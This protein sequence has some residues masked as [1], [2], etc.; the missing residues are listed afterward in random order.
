MTEP[1]EI[2]RYYA[3]RK[4]F[5][6]EEAN[7]ALP[8][9]K[10]IARDLAELSREVLERRERLAL[11]RGRR[12]SDEQNPYAE[13]LAQIEDELAEDGK[14]LE[15]FV[16]EL[17]ELGVEPKNALEGLV[18]F[19]ARLEGRIVYLCWK[20]GEPE[21]LFWHDIEAGFAGRQPLVAAAASGPGVGENPPEAQ[22]H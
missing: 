3:Q 8:L 21:V 18:D 22:G 19:P 1:G 15:E 4:L 14:R 9:V 10:A 17:R 2:E 7:A 6:L 20:L 11:L 16:E 5:T 12:P 13:E